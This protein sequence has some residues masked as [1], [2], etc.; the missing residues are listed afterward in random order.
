[1]IES[2]QAF[3]LGGPVMNN[4]GIIDEVEPMVFL[5]D[6]HDISEYRLPFA[7]PC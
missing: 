1:M 7:E 5:W 4:L 6:N 2:L 3:D